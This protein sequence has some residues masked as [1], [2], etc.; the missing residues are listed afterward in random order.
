MVV[1]TGHRRR[2]WPRA[3][4]TS[5][6]SGPRR[7]TPS[8]P[9]PTGSGARRCPA[10]QA[11]SPRTS[12]S[13]WP[14]TSGPSSAR[15]EIRDH[16]RD[17]RRRD[18]A[19]GRI[20]RRLARLPPMSPLDRGPQVATARLGPAAPKRSCWRSAG[21]LRPGES[22]SEGSREPPGARASFRVE[23]RRPGATPQSLA[24]PPASVAP[25]TYWPRNEIISQ[26]RRGDRHDKVLTP[27]GRPS[28]TTKAFRLPW[29]SS[30]PGLLKASR[31]W[32]GR[33]RSFTRRRPT[34]MK[35]RDALKA[36]AGL[37]A[38]S[39][40]GGLARGSQQ[41]PGDDIPLPELIRKIGPM[42]D[43]IPIEV[44]S[45]ATGLS[46][47]TGPGGN[48]T[49]A[50]RPRRHASWSTPSCPPERADLVRDR[51]QAGRGADHADQHPLA[52]RPHRRQRRAGRGRG[53]RSSPT[54]TSG[55]GS[56]PS[57]T[58]PTSR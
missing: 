2:S 21:G 10:G 20:R 11:S 53:R 55:R 16:Q 58:S 52:L 3:R 8:R 28:G 36:M 9:W 46:L 29:E 39:A 33:G 14:A 57:N 23:D 56:A 22:G 13:S 18:G 42:M 6:K 48:I 17:R 24:N 1:G 12:R 47:I 43:T 32:R 50:G 45:L 40:L 15:S 19:R 51:P 27:D 31:P 44:S 30:S 5:T 35:R 34:L 4:R 37:A 7:P 38:T 25:K 26:P 49:G 41:A 54:R